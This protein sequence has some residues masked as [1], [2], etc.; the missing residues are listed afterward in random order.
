[1]KICPVCDHDNKQVAARCE[2]CGSEFA[3]AG[4][5]KTVKFPKP[6]LMQKLQNLNSEQRQSAVFAVALVLMVVLGA[7]NRSVSR[8][9][10]A[11]LEG[12]MGGQQ[13]ETA[14]EGMQTTRA[15]QETMQNGDASGLAAYA[16]S[17]GD[18]FLNV[19]LWLAVAALLA[20][21]AL[22]WRRRGR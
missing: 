9:H 22:W 19:V 11:S 16:S 13:G 1:M 4:K 12:E 20:A 6:G 14:V 15:M 8:R 17:G 5:A 7:I 10:A 2:H 21:A 18:F 3:V